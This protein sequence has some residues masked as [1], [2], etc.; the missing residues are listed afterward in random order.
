MA[1]SPTTNSIHKIYYELNQKPPSR[2]YNS[3]LIIRFEL[4]FDIRVNNVLYFLVDTE[5]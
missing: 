2:L 4:E 3:K 1:M 5:T